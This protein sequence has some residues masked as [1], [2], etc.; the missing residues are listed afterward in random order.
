M[1]AAADIIAE[2]RQR[3]EPL[4]DTHHVYIAATAKTE[5]LPVLTVDVG[6]FDRHDCLD[7]ID[8]STY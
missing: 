1:D 2:L 3:G 4:D 6:K 8:W 5:R 7:V